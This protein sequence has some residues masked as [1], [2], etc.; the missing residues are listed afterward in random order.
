MAQHRTKRPPVAGANRGGKKAGAYK[1]A[2]SGSQ[3]AGTTLAT[4]RHARPR[5]PVETIEARL[6]R[7]A[8]AADEAVFVTKSLGQMSRAE[9]HKRLFGD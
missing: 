3:S 8:A 9:R 5:Q 2:R 7:K 4:T 6:G 1:A